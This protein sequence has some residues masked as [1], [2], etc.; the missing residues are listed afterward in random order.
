MDGL[1]LNALTSAINRRTAAAPTARSVIDAW[2]TVTGNLKSDG[3]VLVEGRINGDVR[4][5][6]LVVGK[7]ALITGVIFADE[8]IVRGKVKGIIRGN[9]ITLQDGAAVDGDVFH[10]TL[11][12]EQGAS[13][14]G[15]CKRCDDPLA[16]PQEDPAEKLRAAAADMREAAMPTPSADEAAA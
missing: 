5:T 2:L 16:V 8:V 13:F 9:R 15:S 14:E 11:R 4:C 3:E 12:I 6:H 7:D 1:N 10:R